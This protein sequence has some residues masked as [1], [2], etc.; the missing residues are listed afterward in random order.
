MSG[1][2][3]VINLYARPGHVD[4]YIQAW[5]PRYEAVNAEPGCIQYELFRSTQ[6]PGNLAVLEWWADAAA[7][8]TH[9]ARQLATPAPGGEFLATRAERLVG[10]NTTEIYWDR[11]DYRYDPVTGKWAPR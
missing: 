3:L 1:V 10:R 2:R 9:W 7:F 8:D 4:D 5:A 6:N 11:R